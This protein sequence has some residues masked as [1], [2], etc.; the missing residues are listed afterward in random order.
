MQ[1]YILKAASSVVLQQ[2]SNEIREVGVFVI[3]PDETRDIS[4]TEQL[5]LCLRYVNKELVANERFVGFSNL[6]N[7]NAKA[8]AEQII[9]DTRYNL[10]LVLLPAS[11]MTSLY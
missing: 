1:Y 6:Y 10:V 9:R 11:D 3:I 7:L 4:K 2:I 8:L 5:S